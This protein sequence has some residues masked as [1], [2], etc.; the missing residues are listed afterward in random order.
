ML[1]ARLEPEA[2]RQ[3]AETVALLLR[4]QDGGQLDRVDARMSNEE[5]VPV[6]K[7]QVKADI[8]AHDD[9]AADK[10]CYALTDCCKRRRRGNIAVRDPSERGDVSRDRASRVNQ[11]LQCRYLAL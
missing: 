1:A 11:C 4:Q 7:S 2:V 8:V 10:A 3:T 5:A 9:A 6:Q